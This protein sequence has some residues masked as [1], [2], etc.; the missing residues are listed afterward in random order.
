[1]IFHHSVYLLFPLVSLLALFRAPQALVWG[2][3]DRWVTSYVPPSSFSSSPFIILAL[4]LLGC[5][6]ARRLASTFENVLLE[7]RFCHAAFV[8]VGLVPWSF[9]VMVNFLDTTSTRAWGNF[10]HPFAGSCFRR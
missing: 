9:L 6:F 5:C 1:M 8:T 10:V 3:I 4:F 7:L 2:G